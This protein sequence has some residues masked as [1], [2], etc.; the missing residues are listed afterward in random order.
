MINYISSRLVL[1]TPVTQGLSIR[2][3]STYIKSIYSGDGMDMYGWY[4]N[5]FLRFPNQII[6]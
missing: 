1:I 3:M 2:N 4:I 6:K 5:F